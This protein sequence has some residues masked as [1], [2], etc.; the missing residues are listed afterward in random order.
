MTPTLALILSLS[1]NPGPCAAALAAPYARIA[2]ADSIESSWAAQD[3]GDGTC[4]VAPLGV[5]G[6]TSVPITPADR[7]REAS[8]PAARRV[9]VVHVH[10]LDNAPYFGGAPYAGEIM[11]ADAEEIAARS[12]DAPRWTRLVEATRVG[13]VPGFNLSPPSVQ[14]LLVAGG[15]GEYNRAGRR[16]VCAV[17]V[18]G[19]TW[20]YVVPEPAK[21]RAAVDDLVVYANMY[22]KAHSPATPPALRERARVLLE[23]AMKDPA[24]SLRIEAWRDAA[25]GLRAPYSGAAVAYF[26]AGDDS[27]VRREYAEK[28]RLARRF[29]A[30]LAT[31]GVEATFEP[32]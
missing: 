16:V 6:P 14:D 20:T 1:G 3:L 31:L 7:D 25:I 29:T 5:G 2:S 21:L 27:A 30:L 17:L 11:F 9:A 12:L 24:L 13:R 19:G 4:R 23:N 32:F 8:W 22:E 10:P 15:D 26:E 28:V 18:S